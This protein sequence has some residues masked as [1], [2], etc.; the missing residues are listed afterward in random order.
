MIPRRIIRWVRHR[1]LLHALYVPP[2]ALAVL[3]WLGVFHV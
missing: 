1:D 3:Q 2:A